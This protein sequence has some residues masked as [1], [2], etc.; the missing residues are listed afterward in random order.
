MLAWVDLGLRA[1][2]LGQRAR[3]AEGMGQSWASELGL[4]WRG[5]RER[6]GES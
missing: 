2:G 6:A 5:S 4:W 1:W 3:S